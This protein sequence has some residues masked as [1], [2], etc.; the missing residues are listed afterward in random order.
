MLKGIELVR[1]EHSIVA[2]A[3]GL[4]QAL[5]DSLAEGLELPD[6]R[7]ALADAEVCRAKN[8]GLGPQGAAFL[9]EPRDMEAPVLDLEA[10]GD[11]RRDDVGPVPVDGTDRPAGVAA[12]RG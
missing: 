7:Q 6:V 2:D 9:E 5:V 1:M 10:G 3:L 4:E 8:R 11:A 12:G